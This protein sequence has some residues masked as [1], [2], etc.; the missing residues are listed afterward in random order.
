MDSLP[1]RAQFGLTQK[2]MADWLG[3]AR[4]SVALTERGYQSTASGTSGQTLRLQLAAHGLVYD[5]AGGNFPAP[6]APSE[7]GP[8]AEEL[9]YRLRQCRAKAQGIEL[10]LEL[11]RRQTAPHAAR[12]AVAPAL[13]A[14]P[15][16]I[17]D[18]EQE[19]NWLT[20]FE[21]EAKRQLR[22][23]ATARRLL[24]ARLAGLEREA[25]LLAEWMLT[26]G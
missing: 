24:E 26:G 20:I 23:A 21:Q 16:P 7:L 2:M 13:R 15:G 12:W 18:P 10:K 4:S 19:A 17:A 14:Y 25:E 22:Y 11:L 6:P 5:R 9:G 1:L 8:D 3:V